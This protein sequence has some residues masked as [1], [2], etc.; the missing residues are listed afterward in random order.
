MR[1]LRAL[2]RLPLEGGLAA[3]RKWGQTGERPRGWLC[4][5]DPVYLEARLDHLCLFALD[6]LAA[7]DF[8]VVIGALQARLAS[9]RD[10]GFSC[11]GT[12]GYFASDEPLATATVSSWTA[13]G[14]RPDRFLPDGPGAAAHDRLQSELQMCL[15]D[16]ELNRRREAGGNA[17]LNALWFW[18]GG[19]AAERRDVPLPRV[20]SDD[21]VIRGYWRSANAEP[22][23]WPGGFADCIA[24][25]GRTF[26]ASPPARPDLPPDAYLEELRALLARGDVSGLTLLFEEGSRVDLRRRDRLRFWR[27]DLTVGADP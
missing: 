19:A 25:A 23:A 24:E 9:D 15:Y 8:A 2:G 13:H 6:D 4:A 21:A 26:V 5:A 1:L 17:P 16:L 20:F 14:R 11:V 7:D 10:Y 3:L 22:A 12:S 27:R 18:G